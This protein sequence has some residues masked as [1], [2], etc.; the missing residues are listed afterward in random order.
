MSYG[1][2]DPRYDNF[3][4]T[5]GDVERTDIEW[6]GFAANAYGGGQPRL[7]APH[8]QTAYAGE[9]DEESKRVRLKPTPHNGSRRN[10]SG[11]TSSPSAT[12]TAG[13][14]SPNSRR[15]TSKKERRRRGK[16]PSGA[17]SLPDEARGANDRRGLPAVADSG[18]HRAIHLFP[19]S[20]L[21]PLSSRCLAGSVG[22]VRSRLFPEA[23]GD[24]LRRPVP[25][26]YGP[27]SF[28]VSSRDR[29]VTAVSSRSGAIIPRY[30]SLHRLT[31]RVTG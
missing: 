19:R 26:V 15:S 14:G 20:R 13:S 11:S 10:P 3:P 23:V 8:D 22:F 7:Y 17:V 27:V 28:F 12:N 9:I 24:L 5:E 16:T 30:F 1:D 31:A 4:I 21:A 6:V 18:P 25:G 29:S 2:T